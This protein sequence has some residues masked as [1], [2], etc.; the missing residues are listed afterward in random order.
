MN[1]L[2]G[3]V[4]LVT[5]SAINIGHAIATTL[6]AAGAA[7]V[8]NDIDADGAE[9]VA[10]EIRARGGKALA[11]PGS[12]LDEAAI[13]AAF[14]AAESDFGVVDVLVNNAAITVNRTLLDIALED[15]RRVIDTVLTGTFLVSRTAAQRMIAHGVPGVIVNMG[16]TTGHRGRSGAIAYAAAKG[17]ILNL[18]RAMAVELAP[19]GIRVCSVSPTRT[20][21][22]TRAGLPGEESRPVNPDA[23]GIPL[24]RIGS[25]QDQANAVR[26]MVSD[27][28]SFITG[29]DLRVDG[30]A[31][32]T[33]SRG[34]R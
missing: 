8:C 3:K 26:F 11:A 4:A 10:D 19:H 13:A 33:W 23:G 1:E 5:G 32:A 24:G 7:V 29:E 30:G 18:T 34:N 14:A 28:A 21:T 9:R 31:L 12:I 16:S 2:D 6:A 27:A 20:G 17:G 25:P 22:P 15:W